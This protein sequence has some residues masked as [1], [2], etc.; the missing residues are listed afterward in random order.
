MFEFLST[1]RVRSAELSARGSVLMSEESGDLCSSE[2]SV[3]CSSMAG[4]MLQIIVCPR[5]VQ[6]WELNL[7][8]MR[9]VSPRRCQD[10]ASISQSIMYKML[11]VRIT[12]DTSS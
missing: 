4:G 9:P 7:D 8:G 10:R 5:R 1:R 12:Y 2:K 3:S 6:V 11:T